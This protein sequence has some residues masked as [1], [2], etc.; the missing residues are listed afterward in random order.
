MCPHTSRGTSEHIIFRHW[1]M[2]QARKIKKFV[3]RFSMFRCEKALVFNLPCFDVGADDN[4]GVARRCSTDE[5][6]MTIATFAEIHC[7]TFARTRRNN[8]R[9]CEFLAAF[10]CQSWRPCVPSNEPSGQPTNHAANQQVS[11][12]V[13]QSVN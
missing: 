11:Q 6:C 12:L 10:T 5:L 7:R 8:N 9:A 1:T 4:D 3:F 2:P 13:S